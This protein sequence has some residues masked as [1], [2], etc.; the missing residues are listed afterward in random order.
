MLLKQSFAKDGVLVGLN[1]DSIGLISPDKTGVF[2]NYCV[3][4]MF[5]TLTTTLVE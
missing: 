3:K 5:L 2:D 4:E 1:V